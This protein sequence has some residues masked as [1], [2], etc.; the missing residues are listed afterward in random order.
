MAGHAGQ[1]GEMHREEQHIGADKGDPE[2]QLRQR[3]REGVA[4]HF[5]EPVIEARKNREDCTQ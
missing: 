4:G 1:A 5:R 3:F 2:M